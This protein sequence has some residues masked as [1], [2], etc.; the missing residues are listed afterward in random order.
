MYTQ[1]DANDLLTATAC[2]D[3]CGGGHEHTRLPELWVDLLG[4]RVS[5]LVPQ[6]RVRS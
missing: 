3:S 1:L 5:D 4:R 2:P 6:Q